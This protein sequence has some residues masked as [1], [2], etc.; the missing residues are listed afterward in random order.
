LAP[1]IAEA[2][3]WIKNNGVGDRVVFKMVI[4]GQADGLRIWIQMIPYYRIISNS[5]YEIKMNALIFFYEF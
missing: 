3:S 1:F 4:K 2:G 5:R